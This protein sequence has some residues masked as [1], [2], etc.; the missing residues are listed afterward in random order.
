[1]TSAL[2]DA[3]VIGVGGMGSAAVYHLARVERGC[4]T[5]ARRALR[6]R[7]G[8]RA[9]ARCRSEAPTGRTGRRSLASAPSGLSTSLARGPL[10][11]AWVKVQ[12]R[13]PPVPVRRMTA[14][15]FT[16]SSDGHF[17]LD[18]PP[19]A[20]G[21]TASRS[22]IPGWQH[23]RYDRKPPKHPLNC[24]RITPYRGGASRRPDA[25]Q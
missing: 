22:S 20:D 5:Y 23:E 2:Y 24:R 8:F 13:I 14:R 15:M 1:M 9:P 17:I 16:N 3:I 25:M 18:R 11:S 10:Y 6:R 4:G 21:G 7:R 12:M 19:D